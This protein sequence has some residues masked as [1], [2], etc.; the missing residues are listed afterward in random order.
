MVARFRYLAEKS[1]GNN[2]IYLI[3]EP[4]TFF[5]LTAQQDLLKALKELSQDNQVV[6][7]THSC[8]CRCNRC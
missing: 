3:E 5:A 2:I 4:E 6:T 7:T 8:I 1:K